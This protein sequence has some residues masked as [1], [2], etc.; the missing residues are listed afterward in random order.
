MNPEQRQRLI[1]LLISGSELA[2]EWSR[3]LFPPE[4]AGIRVGLPRQGARGRHHREYP[5]RALAAGTH[6]QQEWG[7]V[8]K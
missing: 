3:I 7:G 1:E 2:P 4:K 8:A 5:S 6:L